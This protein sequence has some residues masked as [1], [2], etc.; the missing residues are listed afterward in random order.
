M[1]F[2]DEVKKELSK[3]QRETVKDSN[4]EKSTEET[5]EASDGSKVLFKHVKEF[6]PAQ[7]FDDKAYFLVKLPYL[8][9]IY[10][11]DGT[12][13]GERKAIDF[14]VVTSDKEYYKLDPYT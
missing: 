1:S 13:I 6:N 11:K 14:F 5:F 2:K 8:K 10:N 9:P 12:K 3:D 7:Y 4:E